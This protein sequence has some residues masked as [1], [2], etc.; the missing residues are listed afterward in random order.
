M[1]GVLFSASTLSWRLIRH[2]LPL[3]MSWQHLSDFAW[4]VRFW[5]RPSNEGT[6]TISQAKK[7]KTDAFRHSHIN[8]GGG[9]YGLIPNERTY[10]RLY[11]TAGLAAL[12]VGSASIPASGRDR[13]PTHGKEQ[14]SKPSAFLQLTFN[15]HMKEFIWVLTWYASTSHY[16]KSMFEWFHLKVHSF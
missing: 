5:K 14:H 10:E 2:F 12:V 11:F 16:V 15:Q 1:L 8:L 3:L 13:R 9:L 4:P 7:G 6:G